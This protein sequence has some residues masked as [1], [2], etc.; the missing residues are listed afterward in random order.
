MKK[1]LKIKDDFDMDLIAESGQCFRWDKVDDDTYRVIHG[2]DCLYLSR[3]GPK[4]YCFEC[5]EDALGSWEDY[6]DLGED[7]SSI[8]GRIDADRDPFLHAAA[9]DQKGIRI[10]RQDPWEMLI[11][12]IISQ[13]KNIPGIKRCV[14]SLCRAAGDERVDVRG[15]RY[16]AFPGP[17]ATADLGHEIL[18]SCS[19]GYRCDYILA[20]AEAVLS[21]DLDLEALKDAEEAETIERLT[22]IHGVGPKVANCISLFGLHHID[23][24]PVDVWIKRILDAEYPDGYPAEE[25]SPYNGVYQQYMFA[26]Y[27]KNH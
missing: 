24:F 6:L 25:Y 14:E 17:K 22:S 8:R 27:R 12:F 26:Y 10:L 3:E 5:G 4:T 13:N 16:F 9:E 20:A 19:L 2:E 23:A 1:R 15:E 11:T 21:K 7:Y 18:R